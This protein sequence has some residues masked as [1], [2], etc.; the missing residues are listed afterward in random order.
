MELVHGR[1]SADMVAFLVVW[2]HEDS[3]LHIRRR[4]RHIYH[5]EILRLGMQSF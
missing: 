1:E 5:V 4:A 3:I 2:L